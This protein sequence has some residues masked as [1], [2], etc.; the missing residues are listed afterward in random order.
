MRLARQRSNRAFPRKRESF[1]NGDSLRFI[2]VKELLS[3][4]A[5]EIVIEFD[6]DDT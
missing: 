5:Y 4:C 1:S 6:D 3:V 2:R